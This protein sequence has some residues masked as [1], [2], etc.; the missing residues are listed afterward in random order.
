MAVIDGMFDEGPA[1]PAVPQAQ[2]RR[3][4]Q[5]VPGEGGHEVALLARRER[6]CP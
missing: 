6:P 1:M 3:D 2:V 4:G 5:R